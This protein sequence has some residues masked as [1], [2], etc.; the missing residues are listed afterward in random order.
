MEQLPV[1]GKLR[2][3]DLPIWEEA[4]IIVENGIIS[5]MGSFP[6]L[7]EKARAEG[8][9]VEYLELD[10]V[11]LPGLIDAHTHICFAGSRA[12]DY[13]ARNNG[14]TYLEIAQEGGGIWSTV[15][16]TREASRGDLAFL[17][18]KRLDKMLSRGITT[19]EVKS[20]YGLSIQ[21]ELK[22]LE[23]I[24]LVGKWHPSDIIPTCL[25]AHIVPKDAKGER[26]Y[27]QQIL[28]E[29]LPIVKR[30]QL[31][32][33]FDIFIEQGAFSPEVA[34]LYLQALS[35][36][37][38]NLTVHGDQ[39]STGGSEVAIQCGALS[40]DHLEASGEKEIEAI[41]KSNT[42]AVALPG[43]TLGLGCPFAPARKLLDA[44][45][46]VAIASDWNPGSAPQG[47]LLFQA[48]ILGTFEKLSSAEILAGITYRAAAALGL[49]DRGRIQ[50]GQVADIIAFPTSDYRE[51]LYLQ[52][53][54]YPEIVW[55]KGKLVT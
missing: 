32:N 30:D 43:A 25:A 21:E 27:I 13:A 3:E 7:M 16:H 5:A 41:S 51:I 20:G 4:G 46:A 9:P 14:K 48:A 50:V 52:G 22:L 42:I 12:M 10:Y 53:Q 11:A 45:A 40:V 24:D 34:I 8:I 15:R 19:V 47:D 18:K 6:H 31:C 28:E 39:F 55:K 26:E 36:A 23:V 29:L 44:G 17:M 37:G 49:S 1:K 33:R 38:M 54:M 35:E 2:D